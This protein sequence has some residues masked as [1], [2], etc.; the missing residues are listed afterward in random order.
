M[1]ILKNNLCNRITGRLIQYDE[2]SYTT[3][4]FTRN[5]NR[6]NL[7]T[8]YTKKYGTFSR[9]FNMIKVNRHIGKKKREYC[10][11]FRRMSINASH[12]IFRYHQLAPSN[13]VCFELTVFEKI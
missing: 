10:S 11:D 1:I 6:C 7:I 8:G 2:F 13:S 5:S 3:N 12:L 9:I 4:I